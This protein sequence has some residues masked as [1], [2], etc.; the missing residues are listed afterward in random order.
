VW[1]LHTSAT[2]CSIAGVEVFD[3]RAALAGLPPVDGL[4][5]WPYLSGAVTTSPRKEVFADS[6]PFG[7]LLMEIDGHKWKLFEAPPPDTELLVRKMPLF[8]PFVYE[9]DHFTKT[10]SG[11]TWEKL[12]QVAIF[13]GG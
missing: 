8:A 3:H 4:D 11:Q 1:L 12:R 13:A 2:F 10:G 9:N 6:Q 5:L 7:V